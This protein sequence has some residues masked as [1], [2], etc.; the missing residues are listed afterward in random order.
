MRPA[1]IAAA[2]AGATLSSLPAAAGTYQSIFTLATP[3]TASGPS[4]TH[5]VLTWSSAA[6]AGVIGLGDLTD[7]SVQ[8]RSGNSVIFT[9]QVLSGS[10]VQAL[11]GV[12][13]SDADLRFQF[14][15]SSQS[16]RVFDTMYFGSLL[17]GATGTAYNAYLYQGFTGEPDAPLGIWSNGNEATRQE[18]GFSSH[19]FSAVP[20]PSALALLA[21][22]PAARRSRVAP[23]A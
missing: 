11:A 7:W 3:H 9:D 4:I 8:L 1:S 2:L 6:D 16:Y 20:A 18:P 5:V 23:A 22:L 17:A 13:R 21:F 15:F 12:S 10:V 14:D 19:L